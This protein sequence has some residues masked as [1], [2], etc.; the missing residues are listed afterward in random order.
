MKV[1]NHTTGDYI[2]A[3]P[4]KDAENIV[5]PIQILLKADNHYKGTLNGKFDTA[6]LD[7]VKALLASYKINTKGWSAARLKVAA[8]QAVYRSMKVPGSVGLVIDGLVGPQTNHVRDSYSASLVN[9]WRD[10]LEDIENAKETPEKPAPVVVS[11]TRI[12]STNWPRQR[13]CMAFYGK[14][15]SN[16]V[17]LTLPYPMVIAWDPKKR[18]SSWKCHRKVHD[19]MK[20]IFQRTLDFYGMEK[21]RELRLDR[22]GGT[23]NVR[24]MR[25]GS[26]WSTHAWGIAC[27]IDPDNN[28]LKWGRNRA[29]LARPVYNKF[30]EF[31]YDEGFISLGKERDYDWMHFQASRL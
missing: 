16:Q 28:Q 22:W 10:R 23:L 27:D 9:T 15:G 29:T 26:S 25:G 14:P 7:A 1:Y 4:I 5:Y 31:V 13:D 18:V 19:N 30:W 17:T 8:E 3:D 21:I 2:M 20:R 6:T 12:P 24:K 11:S